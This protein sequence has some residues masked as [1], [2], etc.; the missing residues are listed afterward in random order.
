MGLR[1]GEA[2]LRQTSAASQRHLPHPDSLRTQFNA[3]GKKWVNQRVN[4]IYSQI[5]IDLE[6]INHFSLTLESRRAL[7][8]EIEKLIARAAAAHPEAITFE[9]SRGKLTISGPAEITK[10]GGYELDRA[11][12][13][14]L[15]GIMPLCDTL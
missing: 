15:S 10:Q 5:R 3:E 11:L 8:R 4:S 9:V 7:R 6:S 2:P 12:K 1:A 14:T 13:Y